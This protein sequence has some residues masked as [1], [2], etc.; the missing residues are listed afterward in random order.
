MDF[1]K[2]V[3]GG[4]WFDMVRKSYEEAE[5]GEKEAKRLYPHQSFWTDIMCDLFEVTNRCYRDINW[6]DTK[7]YLYDELKWAEEIIDE[8]IKKYGAETKI[9]FS[10]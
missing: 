2:S 6:A 4:K 1:Y 7:E 8:I 5:D 9:E 10:W 3:E